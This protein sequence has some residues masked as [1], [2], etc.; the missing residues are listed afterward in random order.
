MRQHAT[1]PSVTARD[2]AIASGMERGI[3]DSMDRLGEL[4]RPAAAAGTHRWAR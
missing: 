4:R 2:H 3:T 1:F